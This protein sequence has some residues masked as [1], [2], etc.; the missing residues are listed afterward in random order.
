MGST[1]P[2]FAWQLPFRVVG[3]VGIFW[4]AA[5]LLTVRSHHLRPVVTTEQSA[6]DTYWAIFRNR[7]FWV[8]LIVVLS[9]NSTWRS[10]G[11]W[12]PKFLQQEKEYTER[13][14]AWLSSSF[15]LAADLGSI[16]VG[17]VILKLAR[18]GMKLSRARAICF[19][20]CTGLTATSLFTAIFPAGPSLVFVLLLLGFGA[21]GVF[22][23]Y[24]AISQEISTRHQG[25]VTGT[26][27][28]LNAIYLAGYLPLQGRLIDLFGSFSA[29]LGLT[30]L[31][32]IFGLVALAFF[33]K[34]APATRRT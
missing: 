34:D 30:G 17:A 7:R 27:S 31:F 19:A 13:A 9:I 14:T 8:A 32:P 24:Y 20:G 29:V 28:F 4:A 2:A 11:F 1:D 6:S 15:F 10:V 16:A 21:L 25:K 18:G 33:W 26:L 5:W 12:L 22:P 3:V 23:I